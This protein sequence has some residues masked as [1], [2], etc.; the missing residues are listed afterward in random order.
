MEILFN[1]FTVAIN[2]QLCSLIVVMISACML[3]KIKKME[4]QIKTTWCKAKQIRL[5]YAFIILDHA[6]SRQ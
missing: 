6:Q 5:R 1:N 3:L 4:N 2:V